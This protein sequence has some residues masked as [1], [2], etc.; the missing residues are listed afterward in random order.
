[1]PSPIW[2]LPF[3][4]LLLTIALFPL[5][6]RTAHWWEKNHN[7]LLVALALGL[8]VLAY[9][10]WRGFGIPVHEAGQPPHPT[11]PGLPTVTHVL[12]HAVVEEYL[13]FMVL[14]FSLYVISG[15]IQLR[16]D[17]RASP[18]TNTTFLGVGTVLANLIGTTGASILLIRPLLQTNSERKHVR[19]T[20]VFFIFLV[21]NIGGC[22]LPIGDPPLFLGY[23]RGVPFLW[24]LRLV[25]QW[26]AVAGVLLA[27]YFAWDTYAYNREEAPSDIAL[28]RTQLE[29]L[30]LRGGINF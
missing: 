2:V 10:Q 15:G 27:I 14:L 19:H 3:V 9:Y 29:P 11:E 17:L 7:K 24:T 12:H 20:V 8:V 25:V 4:T 1:M 23:L 22:L 28:D 16:G 13:P 21:S 30:R 26:A 6:L 5:Q 18:L